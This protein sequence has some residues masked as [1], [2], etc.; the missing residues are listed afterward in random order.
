MGEDVSVGAVG[1]AEAVGILEGDSEE[2][3]DGLPVGCNKVERRNI[4]CEME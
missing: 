2:L 1:P 4:S 3:M